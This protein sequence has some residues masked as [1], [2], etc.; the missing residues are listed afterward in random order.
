MKINHLTGKVER[1]LVDSETKAAFERLLGGVA[2]MDIT[3]ADLAVYVQALQRRGSAPRTVDRTRIN[4]V[5]RYMQRHLVGVMYR[6][7]KPLLKLLGDS[8]SAFRAQEE[9]CSRLALRGL[10]VLL[11]DDKSG[12]KSQSSSRDAST[13]APPPPRLLMML[14]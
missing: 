2:W 12:G 3:R 8:D 9:E 11:M 13:G 7:I 6:K 1:G 14:T 4:L 10:A 5:L